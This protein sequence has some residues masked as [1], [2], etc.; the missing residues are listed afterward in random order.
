MAHAMIPFIRRFL[1]DDSGVTAVEYGMIAA[2][3]AV[4]ILSTVRIIGTDLQTIFNTIA[5]NL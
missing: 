1:R 5:P 3:V 4:I 2:F